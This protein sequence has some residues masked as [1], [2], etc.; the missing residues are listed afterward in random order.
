VVI[1]IKNKKIKKIKTMLTD[2][3]GKIIEASF[4]WFITSFLMMGEEVTSVWAMY[5]LPKCQCGP[6]LEYIKAEIS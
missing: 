2:L 6:T 4:Y 1:W 3:A 5:C